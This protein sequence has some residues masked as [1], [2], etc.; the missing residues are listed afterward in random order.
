[1]M[2]NNQYWIKVH[3]KI[4][5]SALWES[6]E[7]FDRR[8][9]WIDLLLE[10]NVKDHDVFYKGSVI[11]VKRGDVYTSI[12][13]L[14][15]RWHW[16]T[17][18]VTRFLKILAQLGMIRKHENVKN[19]TLLTIVNYGV[20]QD[21][22]DSDRDTDDTQT[23]HRRDGDGVLLKNNKNVKNVKN[24]RES[25]P[26]TLEGSAPA[27]EESESILTDEEWEKLPDV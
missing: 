5:E 16:S 11:K 14:A 10:A 6:D 25:L 19:V 2:N 13:K 9:A 18:K 17:G 27:P 3:R 15:A 8:S 23:I 22:R 20:Y 7:P 1:M 4:R 26:P 12:R 21:K 24:K